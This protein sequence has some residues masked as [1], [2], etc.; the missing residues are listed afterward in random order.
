MKTIASRPAI[1]SRQLA[2][3]LAVSAMLHCAPGAA[4]PD[5]QTIEPPP[6][7]VRGS[8]ET[9]TLPDEWKLQRSTDTEREPR[10]K[11]PPAPKTSGD[12]RK[13]SEQSDDAVKRGWRQHSRDHFTPD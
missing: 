10:Y 8:T 1:A 11:E 9:K 12:R 13:F 2:A 4:Q 5:V 3:L 7:A 6:P